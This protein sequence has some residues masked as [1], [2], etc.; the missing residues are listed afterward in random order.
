MPAT[1]WEVDAFSLEAL[2]KALFGGLCGTLEAPEGYA[3]RTLVQ[4]RRRGRCAAATSPY[5]QPPWARRGDRHAREDPLPRRR[6]RK[7]LSPRQHAYAAAHGGKFDDC[8]GIILG[9]WTDCEPENPGCTLPLEE[10]F[11]QLIAPAGKPAI[12]GFA[13]GHSMPTH[14][15]PM[16]RVS[17]TGRGGG[18][19]AYRGGVGDGQR[20]FA[21]KTRG[22]PRRLSCEKRPARCRSDHRR[23]RR[24]A[25]RRN[26]AWCRPRHQG[27]AALLRAWKMSWPGS[28]RW[29]RHI[30]IARRT[31]A[32]TR[33]CS[34]QNTGRT[35]CS[36]WEMLYWMIVLSGQHRHQR[37]HLHAGLR[38]YQRILRAAGASKHRLPAQ[39]ASTG[40]R[41]GRG[42]TTTPPPSTSS[43]STKCSTAGRS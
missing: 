26:A 5:W 28:W 17:E 41:S 40:R 11:R 18:R 32:R 25:A 31:S 9:H 7:D 27:G 20:C 8:A 38:A 1:D 39:D 13:C 16:G 2:K 34:S 24:L 37:R 35:G 19:G 12:C 4:A 15:L 6:E 33:A 42:A 22:H 10:I 30:S 14:A 43:A 3:P 29:M 23:S 36:L 21:G